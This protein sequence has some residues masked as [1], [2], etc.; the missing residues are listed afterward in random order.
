MIEARPASRKQDQVAAAVRQAILRGELRPGER[1]LELQLARQFKVSQGPVREALA[2]LA[3][4]GLVVKVAHRG[5]FVSRLHA[6]DLHEL[7]TLRAS[8]DGFSA[9]LAAE[10][11]TDEDVEHLRELLERMRTAELA[12]NL[13]SLTEAHLEL[14]ERIYELSGHAL[15][16]EIFA[17]IRSRMALALDFAENLFKADGNETE[18]HVPL[19]EALADRDPDRAE[20][21][22]RELALGWIDQ[23]IVEDGKPNRRRARGR[24]PP[25]TRATPATRTASRRS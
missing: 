22:A 14:H 24:R 7:F 11:A 3:R 13:P 15:L 5:T 16:G 18:C 20:Q 6:R 25:A 23:V 4:E 12:G 8:L 17:L 19:L 9:R 1:I 10:R 2:A 21:V